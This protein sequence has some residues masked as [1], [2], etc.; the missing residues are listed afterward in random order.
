MS[1][2][3]ITEAD[4]QTRLSAGELSAFK[5]AA[6]VVGQ[7]NP[8]PEIITGVVLE[9]RNAVANN[10]SNT[11]GDGETIPQGALHHALA[12]IRYRLATRLPGM[13]RLIDEL[14]RREYEDAVSWLRSKPRV[15]APAVAAEI[16]IGGPAAVVVGSRTRLNTRETMAGL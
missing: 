1:W 5:N 15:E 9:I 10:D 16:Q 4:V 11:L 13:A 8:L 12:I 2:I 6:L 7:V 14:R 3:S